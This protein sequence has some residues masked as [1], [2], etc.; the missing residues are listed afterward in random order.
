MV[1]PQKQKIT[2]TALWGTRRRSSCSNCPLEWWF[3]LRQFSGLR[4]Q[5]KK[6]A[7]WTP[8]CCA[9][10]YLTELLERT[11]GAAH[12][13]SFKNLS[14]ILFFGIKAAYLR[15]LKRCYFPVSLIL[16]ALKPK[17]PE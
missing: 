14:S 3:Q 9:D 12:T 13:L 16:F 15:F 4:E 7:V 5:G 2:W 8:C 6:G 10:T 17:T 1:Q 11:G